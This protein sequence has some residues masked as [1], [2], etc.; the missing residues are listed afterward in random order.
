[1]LLTVDNLRTI[2]GAST[3]EKY[4]LIEK[5]IERFFRDIIYY[6]NIFDRNDLTID[7]GYLPY[8]YLDEDVISMIIDLLEQ[9]LGYA[10]IISKI[11]N[12]NQ[13]GYVYGDL[14]N[15]RL[16]DPL[17]F[18]LKE[19]DDYFNLKMYQPLYST[20]HN[21]LNLDGKTERKAYFSCLDVNSMQ[22]LNEAIL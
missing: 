1:M 14:I 16:F 13:L 6:Y 11:S 9:R 10:I 12:V 7:S 2:K 19:V 17:K 3:I 8:H 22:T 4:K 5:N 15:I 18:D 20:Y 21:Y